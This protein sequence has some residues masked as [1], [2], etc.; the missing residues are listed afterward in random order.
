[1]GT[2]FRRSKDGACGARQGLRGAVEGSSPPG[3]GFPSGLHELG[4]Q[5]RPHV[6]DLVAVPGPRHEPGVAERDQVTRRAAHAVPEDRRRACSSTWVGRGSRATVPGSCRSAGRAHVAASA[7]AARDRRSPAPDRRSSAAT[8]CRRS[9]PRKAT[10]RRS[11]SA[12]THGRR[13]GRPRRRRRRWSRTSSLQWIRLSMPSIIGPRPRLES[14]LDWWTMSAS[15]SRRTR[16]QNGATMR[17]HNA[18][19]R[20][21][22]RSRAAAGSAS[23]RSISPRAPRSVSAS[24]QRRSSTATCSA[25]VDRT[26]SSWSRSEGSGTVG[27]GVRKSGVYPCRGLI[28]SRGARSVP[29]TAAPTRECHAAWYERRSGST[30]VR[31]AWSVSQIGDQAKRTAK[32]SAGPSGT[33]VVMPSKIRP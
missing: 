7:A 29:A 12:P 22:R 9:R 26:C 18:R 6:P 31:S 1:M 30:Y 8:V 5:R 32:R 23:M 25:G 17:S 11:A 24:R 4:P 10:R 16:A 14:S 21:A 13:A 27:G 2:L 3:S 19:V 15:R 33:S 28:A 20:S